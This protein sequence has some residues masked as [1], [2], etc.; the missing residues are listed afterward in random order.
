MLHRLNELG[1][2]RLITSTVVGHDLRVSANRPTNG[3]N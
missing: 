2:V 3:A 1:Q